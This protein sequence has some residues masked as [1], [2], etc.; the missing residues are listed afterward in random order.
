[1]IS[2]LL[3]PAG[4]GAAHSIY[5]ATVCFAARGI[6]RISIN[7]VLA[8]S[9]PIGQEVL[10]ITVSESD[11]RFNKLRDEFSLIREFTQCRAGTAVHIG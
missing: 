7:H 10:A 2:S 9:A 1:M 6:V 8:D 3:H 11:G 5:Y 4:I